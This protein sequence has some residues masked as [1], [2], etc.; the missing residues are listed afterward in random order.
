VSLNDLP[1]YDPHC[2]LCPGNT[3]ANGVTN[4]DYKDV[5]IFDNDFP[6]LLEEEVEAPQ[7]ANPLFVSKP[8]RGINRVVCF[9]PRHDLTIPEMEVEALEKVVQA[10][11]EE[12][13][14]L[15]SKNF[16]NHVQIF[17]NKGSV[18][19]CSNPHPHGQI[20]AQ[21][22]LPTHVEKVQQNLLDYYNKNKRSLLQDYLEAEL[23]RQERVVLENEH[24][25]VVVPFWATWPFETLIISRR[26][27]GNI[28]E[29]TSGE[30]RSFA[31]ILKRLT[32]KYDNVFNISFPYSAGI[33]QTP[34]D[35][36]EH[37]E[38]H[39]HM[40]FYPPLLRSATIR[41]FMVGYEM[42]GEAQRD[43]SPEK[44]AA[45]LKELPEIHYK[46]MI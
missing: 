20:W 17:D 34:T 21:S 8:E 42:L 23:E 19:G 2:Y 16:I 43:I 25:A 31:E 32:V 13:I 36:Q 33:H 3:R 40:H 18:M 10:W 24:F 15:G 44:S 30:S 14:Y 37:T 22:S 7:D 12:Y 39:F 5:Y 45:L 38:W 35:G 41:K 11:K 4:E 46:K 26:H 9:S 29:M 27:F 1:K 28:T 6:A